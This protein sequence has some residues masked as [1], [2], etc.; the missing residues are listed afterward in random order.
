ML[1]A[2]TPSTQRNSAGLHVPI[3]RCCDRPRPRNTSCRSLPA[4][5]HL[6][7]QNITLK[8]ADH[9]SV[10]IRHLWFQTGCTRVTI[11]TPLTSDASE[12]RRFSDVWRSIGALHAHNWSPVPGKTHWHPHTPW[13]LIWVISLSY[14]TFQAWP[15]FGVCRHMALSKFTTED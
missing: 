3:S 8:L 7:G 12:C 14:C 4:A 2:P 11:Q 10:T 15:S 5:C 13:D 9:I 1:H 6:Q